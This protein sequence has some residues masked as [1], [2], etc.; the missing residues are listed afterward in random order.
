MNFKEYN[1]IMDKGPCTDLIVNTTNRCCCACTY[2]FTDPNPMDMTFE[3][4]KEI[5]TWL[6]STQSPQQHEIFRKMAYDPQSYFSGFHINWF[7]GEPM[8]RFEEVIKP[9]MEWCEQKGYNI[10]WGITT[11]GVLLD[12]ARLKFFEHFK[13]AILFSIDGEKDVQDDQ[14]PLVGGG[15]S[16][17][18][19]AP[20]LEIFGKYKY[21]NTFRSTITPRN[22][23]KMVDGY[24]L[25]RRYGFK[26]YF[27]GLDVTDPDW[28]ENSYNTLA[29]QF[30]ILSHIV[31]ED[32]SAGYRPVHLNPLFTTIRDMFT[33]E[34]IDTDVFRC[35][36]GVSGLG[37]A[38]NGDLYSCQEHSTYNNKEDMFYIGN[39]ATGIDREKHFGIIHQYEK[40]FEDFQKMDECKNCG[41]KNG[42]YMAC[43]PSTSYRMYGKFCATQPVWCKW[44][45]ITHT[46][47]KI[48][49]ARCL[50]DKNDR[51]LKYMED[52][53]Q[54]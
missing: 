53:F 3:K 18:R 52:F 26:N 13:T 25:A 33:K 30:L 27:P 23:D 5:V 41:L 34:T 9:T 28:D 46:V 12:P 20:N 44:R 22:C 36:M 21:S 48:F 29:E 54:M 11:N 31:Y 15:S 19:I 39:I 51:V 17:D 8:L 2:C 14:R 1:E 24:L 50:M 38:P 35:G 42:C 7:G 32:L 47:S 40:E 4:A 37:V 6:I 43:C 10:G 16:W 45:E 49:L